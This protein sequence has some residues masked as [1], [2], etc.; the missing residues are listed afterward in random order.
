MAAV[1]RDKTFQAKHISDEQVCRAVAH[2]HAD[3]MRPWPYEALAV[4]LGCHEKV[5]YRACQRA[6]ERDLVDYGISLRSGW[7]TDK[8]WALIGGKP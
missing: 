2:Y 6:C 4:E 1:K 7:L 3:C 5:A 8:G